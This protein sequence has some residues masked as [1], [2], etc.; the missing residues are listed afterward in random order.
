[1]IQKYIPTY[2]KMKKVLSDQDEKFFPRLMVVPTI[3]VDVVNRSYKALSDS[4]YVSKVFILSS[5]IGDWFVFVFSSNILYA[6]S[7]IHI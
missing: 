2:G 4:V 7:L 6:L 5:C 3:D 1:M